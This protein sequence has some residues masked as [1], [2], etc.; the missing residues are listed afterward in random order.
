MPIQMTFI[1][2]F[3]LTDMELFSLDKYTEIIFQTTYNSNFEETIH[4]QSWM[5]S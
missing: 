3:I 2:N 1:R 4:F 5:A